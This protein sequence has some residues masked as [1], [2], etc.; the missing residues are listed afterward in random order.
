[1]FYLR[2]FRAFINGSAVEMETV[3]FSPDSLDPRYVFLLDTGE[4]IWVWS[5]L[6]S[7]VGYYFYILL[8]LLL[9]FFIFINIKVVF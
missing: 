6:K 9:N 7:R 8:K 3:A 5:G 2:L 1:M 4:V